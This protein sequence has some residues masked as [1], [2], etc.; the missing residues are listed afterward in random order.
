MVRGVL[1]RRRVRRVLL[2]AVFGPVLAVLVAFEV[3]LV[4]LAGLAA[5]VLVSPR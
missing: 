4:L 2:V 1:G 5:W 3:A